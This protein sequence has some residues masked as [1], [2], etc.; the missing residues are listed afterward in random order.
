MGDRTGRAYVLIS[1]HR[2]ERHYGYSD[3]VE[4]AAAGTYTVVVRRFPGGDPRPLRYH[5]AAWLFPPEEDR[6]LG[7]RARYVGETEPS[8]GHRRMMQTALDYWSSALGDNQNVRGQGVLWS[9]ECNGAD[10]EFGEFIDDVVIFWRVED[11]VEFAGNGG[12]CSVR[13]GSFLPY[14]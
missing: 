11:I 2:D 14:F 3:G 7:I 10:L 12:P 4:D 1:G 6:T 8:A 9:G 13:E 5:V